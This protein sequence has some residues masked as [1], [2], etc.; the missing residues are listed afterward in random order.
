M[1]VDLLYQAVERP[2][3]VIHG[4]RKIIQ[5]LYYE[6]QGALPAHDVLK[7][8]GYTRAKVTRLNNVY[9]NRIDVEKAKAKLAQRKGEEHTS[10]SILTRNVEKTHPATQG[11][12][13]QNI[14]ISET[15]QRKERI[16]TADVFYRSTEL[17]MK[18]GADLSLIN[19]IYQDLE[20]EPAVTRMYFANAYV[21]AVFFPLLFQFI[22]GVA[23]LKHIKEHDEKFHFLAAK[24]ISRYL[25]PVN[26]Y[27]YRAQAKQWERARNLDRRA[28]DRYLLKE[29]GSY[30]KEHM[31]K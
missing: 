10:V 3:F 18:F 31:P 11:W 7:E 17:I 4:V 2:A 1:L 24:A 21:S 26:R 13:I 19:Q 27:T 6:H 8:L 14:V 25:D 16:V 23:F 29:L 22:D 28:I 12:C 15:W 20:V 9:Y 5:G 30:H